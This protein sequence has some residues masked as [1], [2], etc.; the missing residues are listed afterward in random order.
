MLRYDEKKQ[1]RRGKMDYTPLF[2]KA[3]QAARSEARKLFESSPIGQLA[4]AA[5]H[6][7]RWEEVQAVLGALRKFGPSP[8]A[9]R[10]MMGM[11]LADIGFVIERYSRRQDDLGD[12]VRAWLESL[13]PIGKFLLSFF[14]GEGKAWWQAPN[15]YAWIL[16]AAI[17][18]LQAY[19]YEVL[20]SPKGLSKDSPLYERAR[21]A[22]WEFLRQ[23]EGV[24]PPEGLGPEGPELFTG[25]L[26]PPPEAK[27]PSYVDMGPQEGIWQIPAEHPLHT[28]QFKQV[29]SSNVHSIAYDRVEGTLFVR[30]W[31][32]KWDK[33]AKDWIKVGPGPIYAYYFVPPQ[34]FLD[35]LEAPSK[36]EWI[37]DNL[38]IRGT[39][40]GHRFDYRLVAVA[41]GYVPRKAT[42][43]PLEPGNWTGPYAEVF[44]PRLVQLPGGQWI[45]S[46][47]PLETVRTFSPTGPIPPERV[48]LFGVG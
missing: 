25:P 13:G 3:S 17:R 31:Q 10:G 5:W 6:R 36:G 14:G 33:E 44:L 30:F 2:K 21:R 22:A 40:S 27:G 46:L 16:Q 45:R 12:L 8:L 43:M 28:G 41:G 26:K 7:P 47:K 23:T 15:R 1:Y 34:M 20:P 18:Y 24:I 38:R 48:K 19:G 4:Q 11:R 42:F 39:V 9:L 37:W 32:K 35:L 29:E